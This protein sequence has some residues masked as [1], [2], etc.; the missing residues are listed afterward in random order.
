MNL[1][2]T[3]NFDIK[4][5][6]LIISPRDSVLSWGTVGAQPEYNISQAQLEHSRVIFM[7][8]F[9]FFLIVFMKT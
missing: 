8:K 9:Q 1:T 6:L 5:T 4:L 2:K 3:S 7:G